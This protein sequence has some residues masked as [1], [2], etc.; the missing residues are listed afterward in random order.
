M[1][2]RLPFEFY[3]FDT[4]T[5]RAW[6]FSCSEAWYRKHDNGVAVSIGFRVPD[7]ITE[8]QL[9]RLNAVPVDYDKWRKSDTY[10]GGALPRVTRTELDD[11]VH[12]LSEIVKYVADGE[13]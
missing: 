4:S 12:R 13:A 10:H 3:A 2:H 8:A 5:K 11:A 6:K 7:E 1:Y 9:R